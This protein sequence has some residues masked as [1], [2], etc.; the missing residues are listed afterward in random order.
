MRRCDFE[1]KN[2]LTRSQSPWTATLLATQSRGSVRRDWWL[3]LVKHTVK[4]G[5]HASALDSPE[6]WRSGTLRSG[7]RR[8]SWVSPEI[9]LPGSST[10]NS[11][12]DRAGQ[13]TK[14]IDTRYFWIQER[15]RDGDPSIKAVLTAKN[16]ADV[17]TRPVSAS[18]LQQ[19]CKF[20]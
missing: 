6:R 10:A 17:G 4:S 9:Y 2:M 3:R 18:V 19:H 13:R 8:S 20:A 15:V 11:L 12:T 14:H 16:F 5:F 7:K 1:D